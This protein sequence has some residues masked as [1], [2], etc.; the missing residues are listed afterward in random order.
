MK[1]LEMF[2]RKSFHPKSTLFERPESRRPYR[3][4]LRPPRVHRCRQRPHVIGQPRDLVAEGLDLGLGLWIGG[5]LTFR[6]PLAIS[7]RLWSDSRL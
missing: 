5:N 3:L 4:N 7:D 2:D 1:W 6:F